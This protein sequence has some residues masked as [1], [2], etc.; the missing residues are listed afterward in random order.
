MIRIVLLGSLFRL[1][2]GLLGS[3]LDD[4]SLPEVAVLIGLAGCDIEFSWWLVEFGGL[5][6]GRG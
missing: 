5:E 6:F 3:G 4:R 1:L 2:A